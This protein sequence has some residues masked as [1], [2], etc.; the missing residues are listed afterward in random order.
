MVLS[1]TDVKL[2]FTMEPKERVVQT[3]WLAAR[4]P[5]EL[6]DRVEQIRI[7]QD[8]SASSVIR[9]AVREYLE[10]NERGAA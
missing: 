1:D 4:A 2:G 9:I 8:R 3:A 7:Q 10:R 5:Q 6:V